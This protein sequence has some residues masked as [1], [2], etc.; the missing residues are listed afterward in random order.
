MSKKEYHVQCKLEKDGAQVTSWIEEK[1]AVVGKTWSMEVSDGKWEDGWTVVE[2]YGKMESSL[3]K[4][5]A[6]NAG[7][8]L[9]RATSGDVPRGNK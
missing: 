4:N 8:S 7:K 1:Y 3:V 9:W 2:V 6:H 5:N